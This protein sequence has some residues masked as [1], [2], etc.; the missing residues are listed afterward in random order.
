MANPDAPDVVFVVGPQT[1]TAHS[2]ILAANCDYFLRILQHHSPTPLAPL[3]I[4][5]PYFIT[6]SSVES[7]LSYLYTG[8][9]TPPIPPGPP[10][11][12]RVVPEE[13]ALLYAVS[14]PPVAHT[15]PT[16]LVELYRL[17]E[18]YGLDQLKA[19][20][21]KDLVSRCKEDNVWA[22]KAKAEECGVE[23][24]KG[25]AEAFIRK[26]GLTPPG[27]RL[28]SV[29]KRDRRPVKRIARRFS[30]EGQEL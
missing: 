15:H 20:V 17:V 13:K 1:F 28:A 6:P 22:M 30:A 25:V 14:S 2:S 29:S 4:T 7:L 19:L 8:Q 18:E 27:G 9:Y 5:L 3:T 12:P 21:A 16:L 24:V 10:P 23:M 11:P 26:N